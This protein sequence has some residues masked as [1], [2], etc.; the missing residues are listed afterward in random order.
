MANGSLHRQE[1]FLD[2]TPQ[3]SGRQLLV[4][5]LVA[6]GL[7]NH[8]NASKLGIVAN[9]VRNLSAITTGFV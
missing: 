2:H 7:K 9:V 6:A 5:A 3:L 8:E 1:Q 4:V